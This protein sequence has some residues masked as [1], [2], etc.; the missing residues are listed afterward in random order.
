[1]SQRRLMQSRALV[2][3]RCRPLPLR[4]LSFWSATWGAEAAETHRDLREFGFWAHARRG[5]CAGGHSITVVCDRELADAGFRRCDGVYV[6]GTAV[7]GLVGS[8]SGGGGRFRRGRKGFRGRRFRAA[9]ARRGQAA[10]ARKR[11]GGAVVPRV[12]FTILCSGF[13]LAGDG[14]VVVY[15]FPQLLGPA[16]GLRVAMA[17]CKGVLQGTSGTAVTGIFQRQAVPEVDGLRCRQ[18]WV[19]LSNVKLPGGTCTKQDQHRCTIQLRCPGYA[20][21]N[22][23]QG[24][25]EAWSGQDGQCV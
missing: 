8:I 14:V 5:G 9:G 13:A 21:R 2:I 17:C 20:L 19:L 4:R 25:A 11:H 22:R 24:S 3:V 16:Q 7:C 18:T 1:M 10:A 23:T 15:Q 6:S 12:F